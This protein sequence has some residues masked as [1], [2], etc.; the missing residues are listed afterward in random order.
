MPS[1]SYGKDRVGSELL[2]TGKEVLEK[3]QSPATTSID[4]QTTHNERP[5]TFAATAAEW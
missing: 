5:Y 3:D 1:Q 2:G 4:A